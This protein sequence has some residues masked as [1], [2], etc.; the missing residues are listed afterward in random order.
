MSYRHLP[1]YVKLNASELGSQT[2]WTSLVE[3]I[4]G[5]W[6]LSWVLPQ[7]IRLGSKMSQVD[8]WPPRDI[9][10]PKVM[11]RRSIEGQLSL[12]LLTFWVSLWAQWANLILDHKCE[13]SNDIVPAEIVCCVSQLCI[14]SLQLSWLVWKIIHRKSWR[15]N[16]M[17]WKMSQSEI[18]LK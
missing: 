17:E 16:I 18:V 2:N 10:E 14:F 7:V 9:L 13:V 5:G 1:Y 6:C 12:H 15:A 11:T 8:R 4:E 3:W